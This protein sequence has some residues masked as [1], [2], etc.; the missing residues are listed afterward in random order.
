MPAILIGLGIAFYIFQEHLIFHPDKLSDKYKFVFE[1][2]FEE[3]N[4]TTDDGNTI[5]AL[6]FK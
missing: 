5:S 6:L 1:A 3:I 4:Y 2:P